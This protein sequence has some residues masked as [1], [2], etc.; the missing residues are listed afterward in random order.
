MKRRSGDDP[1]SALDEPDSKR[2]TPSSSAIHSFPSHST[3]SYSISPPSKPDIAWSSSSKIDSSL[4]P[5]KSLPFLSLPNIPIDSFGVRVSYAGLGMKWEKVGGT[6]LCLS[7]S[8]LRGSAFI[9]AF[10]MDHTLIVPKSGAKFPTNRGDWSWMLPEVPAM[11]KRLYALGYNI[12]V[13]SNQNGISTGKQNASDIMGKLQDMCADINVPMQAFCA[14]HADKFRK[15]SSEMFHTFVS[16]FNGGVEVNMEKSFYIGDA[17]G[18]PL[19][20]A[21][22]RKADHGTVDRKFAANCGLPFQTPEE[23]FLGHPSAAFHWRSIDPQEVLKSFEPQISSSSSSSSSSQKQK[24][25]ELVKSLVESLGKQL[26]MILMVGCPA[27]GKSTFVVRNVEPKGYTRVNRDLLGDLN[28][29]KSAAKAALANGKS[30]VIDNTNPSASARAEYIALAKQFGAS[31]RVFI[32]TT[33]PELA[34]HCNLYRERQNGTKRIPDIAYNMYRKN[35][36]EPHLSEGITEIVKV[37]WVPNFD[38]EKDKSLFL[39]WTE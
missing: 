22:K 38:N 35:F 18:R 24:S 37:P 30:V 3:P 23:F 39:Q 29:C 6:L 13:F 34:D 32:M 12:V 5:S 26:E 7:S 25:L 15:P 8:S 21:P 10:D 1:V 31:V 19:G 16:K 11:L 36:Q 33:P 28:K 27:S 17:A 9:A 14:S 20:W 4:V 2:S